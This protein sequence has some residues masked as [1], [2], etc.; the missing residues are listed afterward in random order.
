MIIQKTT[1]EILAESIQV[2]AALKSVEKITIKE[3]TQN[4]GMTSTTFYNHF[5][6]K[7]ELLAWIYN[8]SMEPFLGRLG[9]DVSWRECVWQSAFILTENQP[10]YRN[11][12]Q[13]TAGQVSFRY[14][15]NDFAIDLILER[16]RRNFGLDEITAEIRFYVVFYMRAISEAINDWFLNGMKL[17][18]DE[19][20]DL[21]VQGMPV[22]LRP[23]LK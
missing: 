2:L 8:V 11:S 20:T 14:A 16:I 9:T 21:L 13:N 3:I 19:F 6:D 15:T 18:L 23:Y 12:L 1:K 22:P 17:S 4:C 7:Y 10:F 5:S